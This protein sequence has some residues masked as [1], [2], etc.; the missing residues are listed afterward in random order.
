MHPCVSDYI[1]T[2]ARTLLVCTVQRY[3]PLTHPFVETK[4]LQHFEGACPDSD[5]CANSR[6]LRSSLVQIDVV[7]AVCSER[8]GES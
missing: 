5:A 2:G 4:Q 6:D 8:E 1:N 3:P 7:L